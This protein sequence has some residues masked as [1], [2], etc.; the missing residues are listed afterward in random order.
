[1]PLRAHTTLLAAG[2][3]LALVACGGHTGGTTMGTTSGGTG[4]TMMTTSVGGA[5]SSG[6]S[7]TA[8][9]GTSGCTEAW[10]CT[11]WE[12][13]GAGDAATRTCADAK[14]CGTTTGKPVETA[15]L[16]ALD[17][18]YFKCKVEPIL[19]RKCSLIGCHGTE[20]GRGLRVY[21]RG[22]L[23]RKG[24]MIT[25]PVCGGVGDG[26]SCTA[27]TSCPCNGPH[28]AKEWR[29]NYDSARGF[30]LDAMGQPIPGGMEDSS[31]LLAQPVVG[32]KA[33]A[34]I[35]LFAKDDAEYTEIK[36]WLSGSKLGMTCA[37][38]LN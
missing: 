38:G 17:V 22:R 14:K 6:P 32:G 26:S 1:M 4:G 33:H 9:T 35:H 10:V 27:A 31:D 25:S 21:A 20:A 23:R 37:T 29:E 3:A 34:G 30:Q 36:S 18:D 28:T 7:T 8:S 11:S 12:T 13:N 2:V 19:D 16:P 24:E 5:V 15:A